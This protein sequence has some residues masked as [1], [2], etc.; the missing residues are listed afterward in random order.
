[1][2]TDCLAVSPEVRLVREMP[3]VPPRPEYLAMAKRAPQQAQQVW[4]LGRE[5]VLLGVSPWR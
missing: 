5:V 3:G 2:T 1:L 4:A